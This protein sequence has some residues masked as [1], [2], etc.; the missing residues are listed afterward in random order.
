MTSLKKIFAKTP[1]L[2]RKQGS[3]DVFLIEQVEGCQILICVLVFSPMLSSIG[4][5]KTFRVD[6]PISP[7]KLLSSK[8]NEI[9][10]GSPFITIKNPDMPNEISVQVLVS[11]HNAELQTTKEIYPTTERI[12]FPSAS[13]DV[14]KWQTH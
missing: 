8:L 5:I 7:V 14:L 9:Q 1:N 10:V 3:Q 4:K 6:D 12:N 11:N 13:A 2:I